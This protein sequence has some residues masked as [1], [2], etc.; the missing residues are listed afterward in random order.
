MNRTLL[1]LVLTLPLAAQ[2]VRIVQTYAAGDEAV[3]IDPA[4]NKIVLRVPD[5]EAAHGVTF[6]PDGART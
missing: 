5:L 6:S 4:T 1:A 3:F 2:T